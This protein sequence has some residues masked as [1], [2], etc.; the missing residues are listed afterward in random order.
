MFA[1]SLQKREKRRKDNGLDLLKLYQAPS[2]E[3]QNVGTANTLT[4]TV[5]NL[6]HTEKE[7]SKSNRSNYII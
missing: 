7:L 3:N 1:G 4:K 6:L 2:V 5:L